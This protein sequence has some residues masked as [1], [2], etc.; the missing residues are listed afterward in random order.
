MGLQV[1]SVG[2]CDTR[3]ARP[4]K[5]NKGGKN[6]S[7]INLIGKLSLYKKKIFDGNG[8]EPAKLIFGQSWEFGPTGLTPPS[9][10]VGIPKK[11]EKSMFILNF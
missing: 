3:G 5:L 9:P 7:M 6:K 8:G 2:E 1:D 10:Y 4:R 11:E